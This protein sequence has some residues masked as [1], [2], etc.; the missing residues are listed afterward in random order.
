MVAL[1]DPAQVAGYYAVQFAARTDVYSHWTDGGWRPVRE[2]LTAEIVIAGLAGTGPSISG[3]LI[4]PGSTSHVVAL[5][6]DTDEGV[7]QATRLARTMA[8]D[9]LF[10]Y[11][12]TSRRGAHLWC[13]LDQTL[14]AVAIRQSLKGLLQSVGLD[15]NPKIELRPGSN[16]LPDGGLGHCLRMPLMPHPVTG[17][18]GRLTDANGDVIGRTLAEILLN[19]EWTPSSRLLPWAG[20]WKRPPV[21][22]IP[23]D[24]RMDHAPFPEDTSTASELL[25]DLWG[26]QNALPGRT[27]RCPAHED[28]MP[29]LSILRDDKRAICKSPSCILNNSDHGR[30]TYELRK[31][32]PATNG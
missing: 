16:S 3:Y 11:V 21:D 15:G 12:E 29:S 32:A 6:F 1:Y 2:P 5:D 28:K 23:A 26:A 19:I 27:V 10:G 25:R 31:L 17:K 7:E 22:F 9:D 13:V 30:G 8:A 4:A 18:S 14:P 20:R 24:H